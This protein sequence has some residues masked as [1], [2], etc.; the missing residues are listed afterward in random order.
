MIG[1]VLT[2]HH[3]ALRLYTRMDGMMFNVKEKSYGSYFGLP[4]DNRR[5]ER[6]SKQIKR[7]TVILIEW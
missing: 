7:Q 6:K 1:C 2:M 3:K 4:N 5:C